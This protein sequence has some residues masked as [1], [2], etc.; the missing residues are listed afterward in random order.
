MALDF[1]KINRRLLADAERY[2]TE[3]L[4]AG[5]KRG[6]EYV[7]GSLNGEAGESLSIKMKSGVWKDF[8]TQKSGGDLIKLFAEIHGIKNGEA[9]KHF[10]TDADNLPEDTY[11]AGPE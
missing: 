8:S 7:V 11:L 1:K 2:L 5:K 3:W 6:K 9:A 4:P 10:T